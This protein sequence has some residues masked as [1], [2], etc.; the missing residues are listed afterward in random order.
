MAL[1]E[2][3]SQWLVLGIAR[4]IL[5]VVG[6]FVVPIA[7]PF[8]R[9][10]FTYRG[11][12]EILPDWAWIWSNDRDG[13][14]GDIRGWW[15]DN[16]VFWGGPNNFLNRWWW[17]AFRNP[18]NNMRFIRLISVNMREAKTILLAGQ[19]LVHDSQHIYGWNFL[20]ADGPKFH[21]YSFHWI[22]KPW[23]KGHVAHFRIGHKIEMWHNGYDWTDDP[24]KA[25]QGF[26]VSF[27]L[28]KKVT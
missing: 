24:Q 28:Y 1:L 23:L 22:S 10:V 19:P 21:Y 11:L 16:C 27:S 17:L 12:I 5:W 13:A 15:E 26:T 4:A 18:V 9:E 2:A 25:W 8:S 20:K 14:L 6:I 3:L 7:L